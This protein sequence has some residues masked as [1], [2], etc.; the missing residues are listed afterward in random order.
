[1]GN[2][3]AKF[4]NKYADFVFQQKSKDKE[5]MNSQDDIL[6]ALISDEQKGIF[7]LYNTPRSDKLQL[8]ESEDE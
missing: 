5:G 3:A 6:N 1:M 8:D 2:N 7:D 4:Q